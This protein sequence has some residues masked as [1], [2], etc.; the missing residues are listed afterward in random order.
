[1]DYLIRNSQ[2]GEGK[3]YK[4][5]MFFYQTMNGGFRFQ[6][7]DTM[8]SMEFPISFSMSPRN[9]QDTEEENLNAPQ[10]LNTMLIMYKKPQ[11]FDTLEATSA[12]AYASTLKVYDPIRKLE[13]ENIYSL[14]KTMAK[15]NHVSGHP[16]LMVDEMERVL[17]VGEVIAQ[18]TSPTICLLYTSPS[19]RD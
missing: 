18:E 4:N 3:A 5:G 12:G 6:S 15:G 2:V 8:C 14:E 13:E 10:G 1:M 7:M 16:M 17:T 9:T 11:L 19:P